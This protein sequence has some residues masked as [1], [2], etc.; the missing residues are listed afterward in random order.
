MKEASRRGRLH[1]PR[2]SASARRNL[3]VAFTLILICGAILV[4]LATRL[5]PYVRDQAVA[6]FN[7]RFQS[8]VQLDALQVSVFPRP[9]VT[10]GG[11]SLRHNGR[12]DAPPL[13]KIKTYSSS[14][15]LF[16]LFSSPVRLRTVELNGLEITIPPGG[17]SESDSD[18]EI[19]TESDRSTATPT[20]QSRTLLTID[21][22]VSRAARLEIVSRERGK[23]PRT[24]EIH[25]L[26]MLGVGDGDGAEFEATLTNPTP[27]GLIQTRGT[28]GPWNGAEPR[29]TRVEGDYL[30]KDANLNT[31]KGIGGTL[32][33]KGS[34]SGVL[35]RIDV[36]GETTTRD[37]S[38]DVAG[39]SVPLETRFHA[40][41]DGTNGNTWLEEVEARLL[42]TVILARGAVVRTEDVKG[43]MVRLDVAIKDGRIE[44]LLK[45]AV[46]SVKPLMTGGIRLTTKFVLPAGDEGVVD[47]LQLTGSFVLDHARFTN[48]NVQEKVNTLSHR[49][50]GQAEGGGPGVVSNLSGKFTLR[51]ASLDFSNLRFSVPGATVALTGSFDLKRESIDFSG[52]LLLDASLAETTT[53]MK[54][55]LARMAQPLFRR[56]GGGSKLPIRISGPFAKPDFGLDVKRA[57]TPGN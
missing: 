51:N 56:K 3:V 50:S 23:L 45:L 16:G 24:F 55:V 1:K 11:L 36:K 2:F 5:T 9:E 19:G 7:E 37:F 29:F 31:I 4:S 41:V 34:Y 38:V 43:R 12:T 49:G 18:A 25:D 33:S 8:D 26:V 46:K 21:R 48:V 30:F 53:G 13:I 22:L 44:D 15:G 28:F 27:K 6:T 42:E 54:A 57:L 47:K 17:V 14:A 40:V 32:S 39:Q 10:G 35:E 52:D 20:R